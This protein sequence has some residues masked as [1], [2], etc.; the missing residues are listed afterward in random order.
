M[1]IEPSVVSGLNKDY[2]FNFRMSDFEDR[3]TDAPAEK[4]KEISVNSKTGRVYVRR[5]WM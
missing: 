2:K 5:V 3:Y 1:S 4:N